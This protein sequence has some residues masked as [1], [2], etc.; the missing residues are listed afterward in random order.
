MKTNCSRP[1]EG[2]TLSRTTPIRPEFFATLRPAR[3]LVLAPHP[4]D[5]DHP[6]N[7]D[8]SRRRIAE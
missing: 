7:R 1:D 5:A 3:V 8:E 4:E 6:Q 2:N